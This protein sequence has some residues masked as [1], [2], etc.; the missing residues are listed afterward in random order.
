[1]AVNNSIGATLSV[2]VGTPATEDQSGYEALSFTEI[3]N[4]ISIGEFGDTAED[5]TFN[6][7]KLGRTSHV[8]GVKDLGE[9]PVSCAFDAANK[10]GI[11]L[12]N[13]N[14]NSNTVLTWKIVDNAGVTSYFQ[15]R[16]ANFRKTEKTASSYEGRNFVI[17]GTSAVFEVAA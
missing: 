8:N 3:E 13:S 1:M 6:L 11:E 16:A 2:A 14:K 12:V 9:I 5:V 4:V 15:G 7:L 10:V 17:R